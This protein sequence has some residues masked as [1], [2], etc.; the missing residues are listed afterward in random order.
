MSYAIKDEK[1]FAFLSALQVQFEQYSKLILL[2]IEQSECVKNA[3]EERL[4]K[5]LEDKQKCI[6][7]VDKAAD[8]FSEEKELLEKIPIPVP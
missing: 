6:E 3:N 2:S 7:V 5:V 1:A 4:F 8:E